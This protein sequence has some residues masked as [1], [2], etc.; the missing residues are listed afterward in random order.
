MALYPPPTPPQPYRDRPDR[1]E[2]DTSQE[3]GCS[4][5]SV[6]G[7]QQGRLEAEGRDEEVSN[8]PLIGEAAGGDVVGKVLMI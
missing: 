7:G 6:G 3:V 1:R 5:V 4:H 2:A 8:E